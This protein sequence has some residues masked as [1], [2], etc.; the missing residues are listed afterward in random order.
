MQA[1]DAVNAVFEGTGTVLAWLNVRR[2][3]RD[4]SV[5]GVNWQATIFWA[6]WGVWN[7]LFYIATGLFISLVATSGLTLAYLVWIVLAWKYS[8]HG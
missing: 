4:R 1:V 5:R 3:M 6:A 2:L 8:K 7:I